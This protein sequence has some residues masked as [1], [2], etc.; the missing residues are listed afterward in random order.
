MVYPAPEGY[1]FLYYCPIIQMS[2]PRNPSLQT[3]NKPDEEIKCE[4]TT[5]SALTPPNVNRVLSKAS[6][7]YVRCYIFNTSMYFHTCKRPVPKLLPQT[8]SC[9]SVDTAAQWRIDL[10]NAVATKGSHHHVQMAAMASSG[11]VTP[12]ESRPKENNRSRRAQRTYK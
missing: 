7:I 3:S 8:L 6:F 12:P 4:T 5:D 1:S 11:D 9:F 10:G 2:V